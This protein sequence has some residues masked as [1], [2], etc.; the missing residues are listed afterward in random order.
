KKKVFPKKLAPYADLIRGLGNTGAHDDALLSDDARQSLEALLPIVEWRLKNEFTKKSI[1]PAVLVP[2][3]S[4]GKPL[5]F[6]NLGKKPKGSDRLHQLNPMQTIPGR[7]LC[8]GLREKE[9]KYLWEY[10]VAERHIIPPSAKWPRWAAS[11]GG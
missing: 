7:S 8:F 3:P 1:S 9:I 4:K 10:S 11:L 6:P 2:S 5:E